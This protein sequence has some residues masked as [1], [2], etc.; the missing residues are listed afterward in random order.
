ML[1][2][3]R[4]IEVRFE[5]DANA[6]VFGDRVGMHEGV[7]SSTISLESKIPAAVVLSNSAT[8]DIG[9][10]GLIAGN[11]TKNQSVYNT[12]ARE[13]VSPAVSQVNKIT[14]N[15]AS[16]GVSNG[17]TLTVV[18]NGKPYIT[19]PATGIESSQDLRDKLIDAAKDDPSVT[20]SKGN[21]LG[22]L[23]EIGRAHV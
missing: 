8:G 3:S 6:S 11:F 16:A 21:A 1:F 2:R 4:N 7:Q 19:L 23:F 5:T 18:I 13:I 17:D 20:L 9:R 10:A 12:V 14:I 22:E 15:A